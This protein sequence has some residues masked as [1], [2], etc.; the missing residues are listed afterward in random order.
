MI[1]SNDLN[2]LFLGNRATEISSQIAQEQTLNTRAT[3]NFQSTDPFGNQPN[4]LIYNST[5]IPVSIDYELKALTECFVELIIEKQ[6]PNK[7]QLIIGDPSELIYQAF[8]FALLDTQLYTE[9][10]INEFHL[11]LYPIGM[12]SLDIRRELSLLIYQLKKYDSQVLLI[13]K[14]TLSNLKLIK[15]VISKATINSLFDLEDELNELKHLI[16]KQ[17]SSFING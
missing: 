14:N 16:G 2:V 7:I 8:T 1:N 15:N 12:V 9:R 4:Y 6:I 5:K 13:Q 17:S 3:I 11:W 10:S